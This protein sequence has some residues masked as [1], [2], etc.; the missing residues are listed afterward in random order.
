MRISTALWLGCIVLAAAPLW[1]QIDNSGT[2]AEGT[3]PANGENQMVTPPPVSAEPYST[4]YSSEAEANYLRGG[5]SFGSVYTDNVVGAVNGP[6]VSDVSYSVWPTLALDM[7]RPRL[8]GFLSYAPGFTFYQRTS[9]R[10]EADQNLSLNLQYRLSP[11][12]TLTLLD[13]FLK[14]S[15]ILNQSDLLSAP[16]V[17][18]SVQAPTQTVIAPVADQLNNAGNVQIS[19]QFRPNGMVGMSGSFADLYY[20]N[21]AQVP[22]LYDSSSRGGSV[23]YSH[24]LSGKHYIGATYQY[25]LLHGYPTGF[26]VKTQTHGTLLFYTVYLHPS[27]SLSFF[28]GPQYADTRQSGMPGLRIWSP[29]TGASLGWQGRQT[30]FAASY[31]RTIAAGNGLVGAV[32]GNNAS[33]SVRRQLFR[34]LSVAAESDYTI[35]RLLDPIPSFSVGGHTISG[36]VTIQRQLD[37]HLNL[38]LGYTRL[39][40]SYSDIP[41]ISGAPNTNREWIYISYQLARPLGR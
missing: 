5:L 20:P 33:A 35:S 12:V 15:N 41:V 1:S 22:G 9:A 19:Y 26:Q 7:T 31:S 38:G 24:R 2:Q 37:G 39:R 14:S 17:S 3:G 34:T 30:S 13:S 10:N 32:H 27:L 29:A 6:P 28:G 16:P 8:H 25:Q 36:S 4:S 23:F 18:G 11:H 40:Q 21:P